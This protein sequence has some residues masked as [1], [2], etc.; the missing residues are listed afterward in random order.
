MISVPFEPSYETSGSN[1]W[2]WKGARASLQKG[3]VAKGRN[4]SCGGNSTKAG[5]YTQAFP[6]IMFSVPGNRLQAQPK[7]MP[8]VLEMD[9]SIVSFPNIIQQGYTLNMGKL[10]YTHRLYWKV[11][12]SKSFVEIPLGCLPLTVQMTIA[13]NE[14]YS[15]GFQMTIANVLRFTSAALGRP[16]AS[17]GFWTCHRLTVLLPYDWISTHHATDLWWQREVP[18][19]WGWTANHYAGVIFKGRPDIQSAVNAFA[20]GIIA[21][22]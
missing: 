4:L 5:I 2:R 21:N 18:L 20:V 9:I 14:P 17:F 16:L 8:R 10:F 12:I 15:I 1:L 22:I 13:R 19:W 3:P 7:S 11:G 6:G